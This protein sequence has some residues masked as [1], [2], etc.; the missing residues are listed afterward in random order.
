MEQ[1][2]LAWI[3]VVAAICATIYGCFYRVHQ[4]EQQKVAAETTRV[5]AAAER[6]E[7]REAAERE[8]RDAI[9]REKLSIAREAIVNQGKFTPE[10]SPLGLTETRAQIDGMG[11]LTSRADNRSAGA[12]P[13]L[14]QQGQTVPTASNANAVASQ[15]TDAK[16]GAAGGANA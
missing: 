3:I 15:T 5:N 2:T 12:R 13:P 10:N 16:A 8:R 6:R 9:E 14:S 7:A 4:T 1:T 11:V